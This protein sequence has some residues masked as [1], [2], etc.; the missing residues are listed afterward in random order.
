MVAPTA[1]DVRIA[2]LASGVG[3]GLAA[4]LTAGL[5]VKA[6]VVDRPC[7][8]ADVAIRR[9]VPAEFVP[10]GR[11]RERFTRDLVATLVRHDVDLVVM[12]GFMTILARPAFA[13]F[14][15]RVLNFHPSL[16]P[17]F[18]GA[19]AVADALRAG[20]KVTGAT[21]HIATERVDDGPILAQEPVRVRAS[22]TV[23][24]LGRRIQAVEHHLYPHT[25]G[26]FAAGLPVRDREPAG[27]SAP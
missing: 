4:I 8:A 16:L 6:V 15:D 24:A 18:R 19:D 9:G 11:D 20:V 21:V 5:P 1:P 12:A 3:A 25:I 14:P 26:E 2:V 17:A 10:R 13:A 22:D 27:R 7:P 23:M